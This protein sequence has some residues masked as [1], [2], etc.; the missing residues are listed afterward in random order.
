MRKW[1][2]SLL[3]ACALC[4]LCD[5]VLAVPEDDRARIDRLERQVERL[6]E[7]VAEQDE[8][9][10]DWLKAIAERITLEGLIE[11]EGFYSKD[12]QDQESSDLEV[13]TVELGLGADIHEFVSSRVL[14]LWE[15]A[16]G[17]EVVVDEA[18]IRLGN[19]ERFPAFF[20][21]GRMYVPFGSFETAMVSDSLP[22]ELAETQETAALL[23]FE[24]S[25][26]YAS[27][28]A[29]NG[30]VNEAG[31]SDD[32]IDNFGAVAGYAAEIGGASLDLGAGYISS[33]GDSDTLQDALTPPIQD[34]ASGL[35]TYLSIG[36]Q[37]LE[38]MA[39][40][41]AALDSFENSELP[42]DGGG[43]QPRAWQLELAYSFPIAGHG[44]TVA[45]GYQGTAEA[46]DLGLPEHRWLAAASL[47]FFDNL[48]FLS[49]EYAFDQ[50]YSASDGGTGEEAHTVTTQLALEF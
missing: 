4:L 47:G 20:E 46:L 12:Y 11:V 16:E 37:G 24:H 3:F 17:D 36:Y 43:A 23:G 9:R 35:D 50:D 5:P 44:T 39:E 1:M 8:Q 21:A 7:Q 31:D 38:L 19:T 18:L 40:Y 6:K 29:F 30:E 27:A 15:E 2:M 13:A 33:L 26:F 42:F 49:L 41:L 32:H 28:Y 25:G 10:A 45:A 14:F 34:Y 22:L 48:V